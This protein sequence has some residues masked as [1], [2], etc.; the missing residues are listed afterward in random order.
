VGTISSVVLV[1]GKPIVVSE[2][3]TQRVT[4]TAKRVDE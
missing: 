3:D 4:L 2:D 1:I